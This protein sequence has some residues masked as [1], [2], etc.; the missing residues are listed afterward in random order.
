MWD[1]KFKCNITIG[2]GTKGRPEFIEDK[3]VQCKNC[4]R[5]SESEHCEVIHDLKMTSES[6]CATACPKQFFKPR[7]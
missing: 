7:P 1:K 4:A 5:Y 2:Q 3:T 6:W